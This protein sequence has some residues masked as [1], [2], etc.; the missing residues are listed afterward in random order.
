MAEPLKFDSLNTSYVN[1]AAFIRHLR[2][3]NFTGRL[4]VALDQYE[5]DVF[6][7][8]KDA[9]SVWENDHAASR[10]SQGRQQCSDFWFGHASPAA[11]SQ[12]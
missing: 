8:G 3:S 1:L 10:E 5:A 9:P 11:R 7:Y 2:E 12:F 6:L 4:H